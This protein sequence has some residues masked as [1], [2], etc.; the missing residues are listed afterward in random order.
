MMAFSL[1]EAALLMFCFL[2]EEVLTVVSLLS[3]TI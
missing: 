1:S 2:S 3:E